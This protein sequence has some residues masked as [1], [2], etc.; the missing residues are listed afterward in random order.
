[1]N[2]HTILGIFVGVSFFFLPWWLVAP[3]V[4]VY[5]IYYSPAYEM[6]VY[7]CIADVLYG[8][9]Y[10]YTLSAACFC[11]VV[12]ILKSYIRT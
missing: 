11:A 10:V 4:V 5:G 7:G 1:M 2:V 12:Y 3:C 6:L 9:P 8:V